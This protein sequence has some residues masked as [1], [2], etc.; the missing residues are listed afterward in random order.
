MTMTLTAFDPRARQ[1]VTT[2]VPAYRPT[3]L[4]SNI[5]LALGIVTLAQVMAPTVAQAQCNSNSN[6]PPPSPV[7]SNFPPPPS[8]GNPP[9]MKQYNVAS[10]GL[11]GCNGPDVDG[12]GEPGIPGSPGQP[13]GQISSTNKALTIYGGFNPNFPNGESIGAPII[14]SGGNGGSGG[15]GWPTKS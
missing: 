11:V 2:T 4:G 8:F 6:P 7:V 10:T 3:R 13:G 1:P 12:V 5:L 9:S 15:Q 14:S